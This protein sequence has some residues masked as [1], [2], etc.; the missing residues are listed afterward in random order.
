MTVVF[1]KLTGDSIVKI[2]GS[3]WIIV[4]CW[5]GNWAMK[6]PQ[7]RMRGLVP[8]N[9]LA[10]LRFHFD[11]W[12]GERVKCADD[13]ALGYDIHFDDDDPLHE[14]LGPENWAPLPNR[15]KLADRYNGPH[16]KS[17]RLRE[18][19]MKSIPVGW[20]KRLE[21]HEAS[22]AALEL[23]A[24]IRSDPEDAHLPRNRSGYLEYYPDGHTVKG[25]QVWR[26]G[27]FWLRVAA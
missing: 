26:D 17:E 20:C 19:Q 18:R 23:A 9:L 14:F 13:E 27:K 7:I 12:R 15:R 8:V 4:G 25:P 1:D 21:D 2:P 16:R 24:L 6:P 5:G 11:V 3:K 10:W 22:V